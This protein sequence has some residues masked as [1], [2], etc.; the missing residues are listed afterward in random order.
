M[1]KWQPIKTAPKDGRR[2]LATDGKLLG[3]GSYTRHVE[4]ETVLCTEAWTKFRR[5]T[6]S[7]FEVKFT[8]SG[9]F[10]PGFDYL[11]NCRLSAEAWEAAKESAPRFEQ[12]PN[13]KAGEVSENYTSE[14]FYAFDGKS[15]TH[16]HDGPVF[17]EPNYWMALPAP[18]DE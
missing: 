15:E 13:P 8:A 16:D 11:E 9:T 2:F 1:E 3:V 5:E 4:P 6:L 10:E 17:F 18:P 14:A 7:P 12:I